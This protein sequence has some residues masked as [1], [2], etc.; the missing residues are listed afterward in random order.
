MSRALGLSA[1][2]T[3]YAMYDVVWPQ[4]I[5][6]RGYGAF[7]VGLTISLFALPILLLARAAGRL[8]DRAD[9]RRLVPPS[10]LVV[11]ACCAAYP[12]LRS[13]IPIGALGLPRRATVAPADI[14]PPPPTV[15]ERE[16][17]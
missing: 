2:G 4:Y 6:A 14:V 8:A 11:A 16:I 10:F 13:L 5:A 9:L 17:V 15:R 1:V 12:F 3:L 7:V